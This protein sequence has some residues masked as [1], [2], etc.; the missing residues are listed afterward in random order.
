MASSSEK[1]TN[2][3]GSATPEKSDPER[4]SIFS[5]APVLTQPLVG[6]EELWRGTRPHDNYEV[7]TAFR[8]VCD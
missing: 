3:A 2:T 6:N 7:R 8:R 1:V 5:D 4:T